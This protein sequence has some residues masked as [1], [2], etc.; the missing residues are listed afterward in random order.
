MNSTKS[1]L[2]MAGVILALAFTFNACSNESGGGPSINEP[3]ICEMYPEAWECGGP[4]VD[5]SSSSLWEDV[6]GKSSSSE[7]EDVRSSSSGNGGN[8]LCKIGNTIVSRIVGPNYDVTSDGIDLVGGE[9]FTD[10]CE[11]PGADGLAHLTMPIGAMNIVEGD[12]TATIEEIM[13]G[14]AGALYVNNDV[15]PFEYWKVKADADLCEKWRNE[16]RIM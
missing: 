11:I 14:P 15:D 8:G 6:T 5:P 13:C 16:G 4:Q 10:N 9:M 3:D 2:M 1:I 12:P 7:K